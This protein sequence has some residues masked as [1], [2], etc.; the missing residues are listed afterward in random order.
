MVLEKHRRTIN[1]KA[2]MLSLD[3][4]YKPHHDVTINRKPHSITSDSTMHS[5]QQVNS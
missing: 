1:K 4:T 3:C 2:T 5:N